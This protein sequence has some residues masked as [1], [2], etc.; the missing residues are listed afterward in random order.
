M[1]ET[2]PIEP[3]DPAELDAILEAALIG[4]PKPRGRRLLGIEV[5]RLILDE[6][7]GESAPLSFCRQLL[8]DLATDID[9]KRYFDGDVINQPLDLELPLKVESSS[10][11]TEI[12]AGY[13]TDGSGWCGYYNK[14]LTLIEGSQTA[15]P[16]WL[17]K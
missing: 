9:G 4:K 5:E 17:S 10:E 15:Y 13:S 12:V 1:P 16:Q 8:D 14:G 2:H 6:S 3:V 11:G 7:T